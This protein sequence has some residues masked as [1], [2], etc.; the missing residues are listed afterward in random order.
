ML[1]EPS[2][3]SDVAELEL[4]MQ[5]HLKQQRK[6][7]IRSKTPFVHSISDAEHRPTEIDLWIESVAKVQKSKPVAT[8]RG[9]IHA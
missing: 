1:K 4:L 8:V 3:N 7:F 2:S 5:S 9:W 6:A